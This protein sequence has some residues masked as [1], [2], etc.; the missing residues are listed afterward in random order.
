MDVC[1]I[2]PG[3][4][5]YT[6]LNDCSRY[7]VLRLY[8]RASASS[9]LGFSQSRRRKSRHSPRSTHPDRPW[10]R[11]LL[12]SR[13]TAPHGLGHQNSSPIAPRSPHLNGKVERTH[14]AD[15]EEFWDTVDSRAPDIETKLAEWQH[16]WNWHRPHT[17]LGGLSPIDRVCEQIH[18]TPLSETVESCTYDRTR[19]RIGIADYR[20]DKA[21]DELEM[22][23]PGRHS[24]AGNGRA[25][26]SLTPISA[27]SRR[28]EV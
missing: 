28:A 19:E 14:R 24:A 8:D 15:R 7:K 20:L 3:I 12:R 6:A 22:I 10:P 27:V 9:T 18:K 5:Q 21:L 26:N 16:H 23:S 2:R 13:S 4:Y 17:A 1:K 11:V 25:D